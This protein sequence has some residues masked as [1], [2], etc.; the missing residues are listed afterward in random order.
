MATIE[1]ESGR[2][3]VLGKGAPWEAWAR[4]LPDGVRFG[5]WGNTREAAE[6]MAV[7]A[8]MRDEDAARHGYDDV[9]VR[10]VGYR[11]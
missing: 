10:Q 9:M 3:R 5:G 2:R 6:R 7:E 11:R 4:H 8:M 1:I